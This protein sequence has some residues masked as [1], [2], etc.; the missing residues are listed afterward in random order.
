[1]S[2]DR[3]TWTSELCQAH[4]FINTLDE[5]YIYAYHMYAAAQAGCVSPD[6]QV[7]KS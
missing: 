4:V 3:M 7:H 1:M 5:L 2:H 6:F